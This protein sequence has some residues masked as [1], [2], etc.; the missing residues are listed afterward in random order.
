LKEDFKKNNLNLFD[1]Q[2]N[3]EARNRQRFGV[4]VETEQKAGKKTVQAAEVKHDSELR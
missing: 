4:P 1:A 2:K 3:L